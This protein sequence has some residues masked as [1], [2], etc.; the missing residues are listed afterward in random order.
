MASGELPRQEPRG[1]EKLFREGGEFGPAYAAG[2]DAASRRDFLRLAGFALAG[3]SVAGCRRAPVRHALPYLVQ[4]EDVVAGRAAYY[5]SV[6]GACDAGCG[7]LVKT[8]DGRP[9]KLE[10]NPSHPLSRGGLCAAGQASLLGLYDSHRLKRPS[11]AGGDVEWQEVDTAVRERLERLRGQGKPLRLLTGPIVSPTARALVRKFLDGFPGARHVV[12]DARFNASP[13]LAAH[14]RTHGARV[15][16]RYYFDKANVYASFDADF[17]GTWLSPVEFTAGYQGGRRPR[18]DPPEM[19]YHVQFEP[20]LSL[21]GAKADRRYAVHPDELGTV[22]GH[23]AVRLAARAGLALPGERPA[24]LPVPGP[25]LDH[26]AEQLWQNRGRSLVLCGSQDLELQVLANYLNHALGNYGATIDVARPA[27]QAQGD[28]EGLTTLMAEAT[29]GKVGALIIHGCNPVHDLPEGTA[30]AGAMGRMSLVVDLAERLDETARAAEFVCPVPHALEAWG[31]AEPAEGVV[32]IA[33]PAL[34]SLGDTRPLPEILAA[35]TGAANEKRKSAYELVRAHWEKEIFPR[36]QGNEPFETF[37]NQTL[38]EGVALVRPNPVKVADFHLETVRLP[39][40]NQVRPADAYTLVLY[41]KVGVPESAH[42]YNAW[43]H[44]LPDPVTKVTWD[45]YACLSPAAADALGVKDG[46]VVRLDAP[47]PAGAGRTLE[48]PAF[49]Q[50]GQHDRVVAVALGYGSALSERFANV[51][52]HWLG[53]RPTVGDGGRV[54]QNAAALLRWLD[55]AVRRER[56][57]VRIAKT[58]EHRPLASTQDYHRL[59]P[60]AGLGAG[61]GLAESIVRQATLAET[62]A[63]R[64]PLPMAAP[65]AELWPDDHPAEGA[66]WGMVIDQNACTGCS[67]CVIA[68]QA[69]NNIPVVGKDEVRRHREMHWLRVDRYYAEGDGG[70]DV[71][72]QPML[73]QHCGNAPCEPVCPVL[74]TVHSDEGLNQQIYNRCVG[75]R[76]CANNCPYKVRRFNWFDYARD[77]VLQNLSLN[78]DVTVRS[79]GVMEKCTFCVQRIQDAK[80]RAAA[81]APTR[82]GDLQTACQQSCPAGVIVF[83]NLSDPN[84][85][86]ARLTRDARAYT[87][88]EELNVRPSVR[89]L[90]P[91]RNRPVHAEEK[92]N[93]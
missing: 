9:I 48:L 7:T 27:Y 15:R 60:P 91:V 34:A 13:I 6:C 5:A 3:V 33:Q 66:R 36:R 22:M 58:G 8:R 16:P 78:P 62:K 61:K 42:A 57:G 14:A 21:T 59:E 80:G 12:L 71:V 44:E 76:Y 18:G 68:C 74:A 77:D 53:A 90:M 32:S 92:G 30:L 50:P 67:A 55:G 24:E 49:V 87:V 84:S 89:Y 72:L 10:G 85:R 82:D 25:A 86:V 83:G 1:R 46:D 88:L 39:A 40:R 65:E 47:D 19:S 70:V 51:G 35:W 79:R 37:W 63:G 38:H 64:K 52:P 26:L 23:L 75:T 69:E 45:N 2:A 11:R 29:E 73:C 4:P 17:L 93:G 54:G 43:L 31:D 41:S 56:D 28:D 20:R 81:G